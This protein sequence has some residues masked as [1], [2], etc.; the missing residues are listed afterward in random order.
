MIKN[1]IKVYRAMS[2]MTQEDLAKKVGV[3]RQTIHAIEN[4]KYVPS[5]SLA[6]KIANEFGV[7]INKVFQFNK[8]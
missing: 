8:E 5:L 7:D 3:V 1:K 4:N 6:F 2:D